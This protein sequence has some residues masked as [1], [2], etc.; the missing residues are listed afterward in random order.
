MS[1]FSTKILLLSTVTGCLLLG[2]CT[3]V[4]QQIGLAKLFNYT[5]STQQIQTMPTEKLY[6]IQ[7][8]DLCVSYYQTH[9]PQIKAEIERRGLVSGD[10]WSQVDQG[11]VSKG[12]NLCEVLAS[13]GK[14]NDVTT[15]TRFIELDY[16]SQTIQL[17]K[18]QGKVRYE[19]TMA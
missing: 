7:D 9:P 17:V 13:L 2:G 18:P 1:Q 5:W 11:K 4:T 8:N 12:M 15:G 19:V 16:T 3:Y 14:P 6:A 10:E